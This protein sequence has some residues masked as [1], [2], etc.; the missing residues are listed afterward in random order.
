M[1]KANPGV[2]GELSGER[3]V[4]GGKEEPAVHLAADVLQHSMGNGIAIKGAGT[5][6]QLIQNHQTVLC[7]MLQ[8]DSKSFTCALIP[9]FSADIGFELGQ[10]V[11]KAK[12]SNPCRTTGPKFCNNQ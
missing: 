7:G 4:V 3:M 5:T 10:L 11:D 1:A 6:T 12:P 8:S 9:V 2:R